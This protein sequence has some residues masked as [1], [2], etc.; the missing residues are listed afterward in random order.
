MI[1]ICNISNPEFKKEIMEQ[2]KYDLVLNIDPFVHEDGI[3]DLEP[4]MP[5]K[6]GSRPLIERLYNEGSKADY[7]NYFNNSIAPQFLSQLHA[8]KTE[9][10]G[11][12]KINTGNDADAQDWLRLLAKADAKGKRIAL[13][14][15]HTI[16]GSCTASIVTGLLQGAGVNVVQQEDSKTTKKAPRMTQFYDAYEFAYGTPD[17]ATKNQRNT[18]TINLSTPDTNNEYEI[19]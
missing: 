8:R 10:M 19:T 14:T 2:G 5:S 11:D 15:G 17:F 3:P 4:L 12:T 7:K 16:K 18:P 13:T 1:S 9:R 6:K